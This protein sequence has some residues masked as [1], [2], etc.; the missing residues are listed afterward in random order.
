M[1]KE[2][3]IKTHDQDCFSIKLEDNDGILITTITVNDDND[4]PNNKEF[5]ALTEAL[6]QLV[7]DHANELISLYHTYYKRNKQ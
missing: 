7:E 2:I 4:R 6:Y 3:Y 1:V 5:S